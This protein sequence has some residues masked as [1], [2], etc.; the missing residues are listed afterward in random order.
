MLRNRR[1]WVGLGVVAIVLVLVGSFLALHRARQPAGI[2]Q[3]AREFVTLGLTYGHAND[4]VLDGYFGPPELEP[5]ADEPAPE[6]AVLRANLA[7]LKADIESGPPSDRAD[8]L[9]A[10]IDS[11]IALI[12]ANS[13]NERMSFDEEA[14][15]IYG[16]TIPE[17]DQAAMRQARE[18][19]ASLLP[20]PEPL[21]ERVA[22]FETAFVVPFGQRRAVFMRALEEC[23]ARTASHWPLPAN[24]ELDVQWTDGV[25][26]AWHRYEGDS[27]STLQI[28]PQ[29][30]AFIGSALDVACHEAYPGH[31]AQFLAMSER[32]GAARLPVEETLVFVQSPGQLLREGAAEY[33]V[34]LAFPPSERAAFLR[35]TLFPLAGFNPGSAEKYVQVHWLVAQ[36][37]AAST[38]IIRDYRDGRK[39]F[40]DTSHAL[41]DEAL[42]ASPRALLNFVDQN[43]AYV[44]GY[45]VARDL[46]RRCVEARAG[47]AD[48]E[49][50]SRWSA[51]RAIVAA[52]DVS[53]LQG[54]QCAA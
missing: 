45:S 22:K 43:R 21:Y 52:T 49:A 24:D 3:Q 9:S 13:L 37:A 53:A 20:G 2:E 19:L 34:Q 30:I 32:S 36:L 44:L 10:R 51:L 1:A 33:G 42:I 41:E 14:Q 17:P 35:D 5:P 6:P 15:R 38:P 4:D 39:T 11:L 54:E 29:A 8:R 28:N 25:D 31:H 40:Y 16:L 18:E 26:A 12:D 47:P 50:A 27:R 23:K 7:K 46:V 48:G